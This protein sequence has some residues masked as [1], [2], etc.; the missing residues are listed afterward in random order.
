MLK[1]VARVKDHWNE[2][3]WGVRKKKY[4]WADI[5]EELVTDDFHVT[6]VDCDRK[7]RNLKVWQSSLYLLK[8]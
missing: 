7:W 2:F 6:G 4:I 1:L 3:S 8:Y 5:A